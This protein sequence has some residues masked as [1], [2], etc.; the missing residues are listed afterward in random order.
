M[1]TQLDLRV[2][3]RGVLLKA[4]IVVGA[5]VGLLALTSGQAFASRVSCG[6]TITKDTRLTKDLVDC[7]GNGIVIGADRITLDLNGH[8][9]DGVGSD[10]GVDNS[11]G[12]EGVSVEGGSIRDFATG[13]VVLG[14]SDNRLR[15]LSSSH[16]LFGGLLVVESRRT[17]IEGST[18]TANGLTTDQAGLIVFDSSEIRIERNLVVF[19]GDIGMFLIGVNASRAERNSISGNPEAGIVFEGS[20]NAVSRNRVLKN[21]DG[22]IV[23]G[24]ANTVVGN[25]IE[26]ASGCEDGGCGA[27]IAIESGAR[28]VVEGNDIARAAREGIRVNNFDPETPLSGTVIRGNVVRN[29][30]VDGIAIATELGAP[31]AVTNTLVGHNIAVGAGDDGIDVDSPATTLTGNLAIH[32]GDLGIEAAPGVSDGGGNKARA[33][34]N[35]AQCTNVACR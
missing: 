5:T 28:N 30:G 6:Q 11:A 25:Q 8:A 3:R 15:R 29:A 2:S 27:G 24:N 13:I 10:V 12:H 20:G 16:N 31:G 26:D 1:S 19:N 18:I 14:A 35:R 7:P 34:G 9:I 22:I 21:G 23:S 4:A 32:N 17:Q 33:N